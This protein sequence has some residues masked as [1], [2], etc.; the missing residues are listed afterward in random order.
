MARGD[1]ATGDK[2]PREK[3]KRKS[4][5]YPTSVS[6]VTAGDRCFGGQLI[7]TRRNF[8]GNPS[9]GWYVPFMICNGRVLAEGLSKQVGKTVK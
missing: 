3:K 4:M 5:T 9:I 1:Y 8:A 6:T 7:Q 2:T